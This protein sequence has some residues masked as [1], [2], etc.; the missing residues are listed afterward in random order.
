MR[1]VATVV[2]FEET[3]G[4]RA[5]GR[6]TLADPVDDLGHFAH[7]A[8][9]VVG[10]W[11]GVLVV[12]IL[13]TGRPARAV[14]GVDAIQLRVTLAGSEGGSAAHAAIMDRRLRLSSRR[15]T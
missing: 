5:A 15:N 11:I 8:R 14:R 7:I 12:E 2:D 9:E 4:R 10:V 1:V 13:I 3:C 6:Q